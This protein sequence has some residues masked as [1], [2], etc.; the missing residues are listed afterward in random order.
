MA[1][2]L[3]PSRDGSRLLSMRVLLID[4]SRDD[5][6][7]LS[8][9]LE[10]VGFEIRTAA[11][12]EQAITVAAEFQPD[13]VCLDISLPKMDGYQ[14]AIALRQTA[15][16]EQVT[17]ISLSG[18]NADPER[19]KEAGISQHFQKPADFRLIGGAILGAA[20]TMNCVVSAR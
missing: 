1:H 19:A 9:L 2:R 4:D 18:C 5:I 13:A 7:A 20:G 14:L 6:W 17:I 8:H 12:A 16:L 3:S 10:R 15:G 11:T